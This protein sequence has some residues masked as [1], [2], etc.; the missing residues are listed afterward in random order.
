MSL[1]AFGLVEQEMM[2]CSDIQNDLPIY[3]DGRL[4]E[5]DAANVSAHLDTCPVCRG[6]NAEFVEM[7]SALQRVR[8]PDAPQYL[9]AR[10]KHASQQERKALRTS[11]LPF[12][13]DVRSWMSHTVMPYSVGAVASVVI[14]IGLL[15]VLGSSGGRYSQFSKPSESGFI[16]AQDRDPWAEPTVDGVSPV[17]FA[18]SRSDV[19]T[20]SPSVNPRGALVAMA[21]TLV[22]GQMKD[23]EVVVIADV[24][25]DGVAQIAQ[26][27]ESSRNRKAVDELKRAFDEDA[28]LSSPF[29]PAKLE[30]RPESVRVVLRF[31]SVNVSTGIKKNPKVRL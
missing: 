24:F 4:S 3:A 27:V 11:W 16:L 2:K 30:N 13:A 21:N 1:A 20:E 14:G 8:R 12:P 17:A 19:S 5:A 31:Q 9:A 25:S 26:V 22:R 18:R 28:K 23:E 6:A 15:F 29:V 10:V 7:R